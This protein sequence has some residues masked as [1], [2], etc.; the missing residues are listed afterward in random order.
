EL[1]EA[2]IGRFVE[3]YGLPR[4]DAEVLVS[5][6][7]LADFFE[8]T[9]KLYNNPKEVSNWMMCD[10]TRHLNENNI[11]IAESKIT[12]ENLVEMIKLIEDDVISGKIA[13]RVL[14]L[15]VLTGKA[16]SQIIKEKGWVKI[17]SRDVLDEVL[18][19]VFKENP[20]CV[21]DALTDQNAVN[22]LV[23]QLMK[24]T[25]GKADPQLANKMIREKLK[26]VTK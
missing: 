19:K 13:K 14:P 24:E 1:P 26:A 9:L 20:K 11:D 7:S 3:D 15:T 23:G 4:Y 5:D 2:R 16:P 22:Y 12:P 21:E 10:L 18:E 17:S 25:R 8:K 6:K